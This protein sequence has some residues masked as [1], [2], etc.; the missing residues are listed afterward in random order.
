MGPTSFRA[1]SVE[2]LVGQLSFWSVLDFTECDC[3]QLDSE[4][5][6][7]GRFSLLAL[8]CRT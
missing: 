6:F 2:M 1:H 4:R 5:T 3:L 8:R 7:D